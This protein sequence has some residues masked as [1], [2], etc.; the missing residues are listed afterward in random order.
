[1]Q[2]L[3]III[4]IA[5]IIIIVLVMVMVMIVK[6]A[7]IIGRVASAKVQIDYRLCYAISKKIF[8][9]GGMALSE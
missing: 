5:I 2:L 4:I 6:L 7:I 3:Y 8:C 9:L 1:M